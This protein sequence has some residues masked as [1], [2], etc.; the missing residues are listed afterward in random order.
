MSD[1][2]ATIGRHILRLSAGLFLVAISAPFTYVVWLSFAP[3]TLLDPPTGEWSVRWYREF[4]TS[5]RWTTGTVDD[6]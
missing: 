3:G 5:P 6:V 2:I 4:L 1:I